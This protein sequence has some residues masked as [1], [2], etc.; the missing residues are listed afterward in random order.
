MRLYKRGSCS[1]FSLAGMLEG[2]Q[3]QD[4]HFPSEVVDTFA[5][6]REND[7]INLAEE[8]LALKPQGLHYIRPCV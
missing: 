1:L 5:E 7:V 4:K 8:S 6:V 2:A 3:A